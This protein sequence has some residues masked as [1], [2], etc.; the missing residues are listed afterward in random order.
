MRPTCGR[1]SAVS[2]TPLHPVSWSED[3]ETTPQGYTVSLSL[4]LDRPLR[5][6]RGRRRA[7]IAPPGTFPLFPRGHWHSIAPVCS[8]SE[9]HGTVWGRFKRLYV[10]EIKLPVQ[11]GRLQSTT[12]ISLFLSL[13]ISHILILSFSLTCLYWNQA[14]L[15]N[16]IRMA[17]GHSHFWVFT[18]NINQKLHKKTIENLV[19]NTFR[20][21]T[22]TEPKQWCLI[23]K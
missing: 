9:Q 17:P 11:G 13:C 2:E 18:E 10:V 14:M 19:R 5:E 4:A 6:W 7:A 23:Y 12:T 22:Q 20:T 8:L 16:E 21:L 1:N 15:S 3:K